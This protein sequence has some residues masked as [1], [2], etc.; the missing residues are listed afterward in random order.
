[1]R[2]NILIALD[3][4]RAKP[5]GTYSLLLRITHH[6]T[7]GQISLGIHLHPKDWDEKKRMIKSS[8]KGTESVTRLN[9]F[10]LKQK[11]NA[12]DIITRLEESKQLA[13]LSVHQIKA[14]IQ[15]GNEKSSFYTYAEQC[16]DQMKQEQR[17]GNARTYRLVLSALKFYMAQKPLNF[18]DI[19][20]AFLKKFESHHLKN[21]NS[22]NG[23]SVY[24]RTMRAIFNRAIKD[25]VIDASIYPFKDFSIKQVKTRKRAIPIADIMKIKELDCSHDV[26]LHETKLYFLFS[27]YTRGI[28][29]SDMAHLKGSNIING[30]ITF[31]RVK[32]N[33]P[34][35]IKITPDIQ[36]IIDYFYSGKTK[37]AYIFPIIK[38][39][40]PEDQYKDVEWARNRYNKRLQKIA[41]LCEIEENLTSYVSRHSFAT[42]AKNL[43]VPI[44]TISDMLGHE[45]TKTTEIYLDSLP[46]DIMDDY[47]EQ[48]IN[49][50][51]E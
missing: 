8:Y 11:T 17:I 1:M 35:D 50:S 33:K 19:T 31:Q 32:T 44:A 12:L 48:I 14:L 2:T 18:E 5:D 46:S 16:I 27:F 13:S 7:V 15:K 24:L 47:H 3:N 21:G 34:Y 39:T 49:T 23:L 6:R 10:I 30:R 36:T 40:T 42:R 45:S 38:R 51:K 29:F 22:Y 9:N 26:L 41:E 25:R 37:N 28:P 43:G 20:Y 4:R